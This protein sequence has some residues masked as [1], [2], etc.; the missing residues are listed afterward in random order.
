MFRSVENEQKAFLL[1]LM[2][3]LAFAS[4]PD[5]MLT[6]RLDQSLRQEVESYA[7]MPDEEYPKLKGLTNL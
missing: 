7:H 2:E 1:V 4:N 6:V 3:E 5:E